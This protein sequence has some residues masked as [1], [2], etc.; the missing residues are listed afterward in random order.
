[1]EG[2]SWLSSKYKKDK[3]NN[4][5]EN[6]FRPLYKMSGDENCLKNVKY[7]ELLKKCEMFNPYMFSDI[8]EASSEVKNKLI[9][10][11]LEYDGYYYTRYMK[12]IRMS[13]DVAIR[14]LRFI[15]NVITY[16]NIDFDN[17]SL[18]DKITFYCPI[19]TDNDEIIELTQKIK[20]ILEY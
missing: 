18:M 5:L 15:L 11:I 9:T 2:R 6:V 4:F 1:M 13:D 10:M 17:K 3:Y 14:K 8:W 20:G 7:M 16:T 12:N 19:E